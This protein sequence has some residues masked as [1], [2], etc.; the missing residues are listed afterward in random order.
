M[1]ENVRLYVH[2][3]AKGDLKIKRVESKSNQS[4]LHV[5]AMETAPAAQSQQGWWRRR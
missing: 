3:I 1:L 2:S 4:A 5:A